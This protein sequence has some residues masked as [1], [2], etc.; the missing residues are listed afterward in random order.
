M[1]LLLNKWPIRRV[2][3]S[4]PAMPFLIILSRDLSGWRSGSLLPLL[5][6]ALL[7]SSSSSSYL[8]ASIATLSRFIQSILMGSSCTNKILVKIKCCCSFVFTIIAHGTLI[9]SRCS[10][11]AVVNEQSEQSRAS[12][13]LFSLAVESWVQEGRW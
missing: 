11:A 8:F 13:F 4:S 10:L 9:F 5:C 2:G 1:P 3:T 6:F 12:R 7:C